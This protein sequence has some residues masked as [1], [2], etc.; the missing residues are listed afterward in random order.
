MFNKDKKIELLSFEI[1]RLKEEIRILEGEI[2]N[3]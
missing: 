1:E 3:K 2:N